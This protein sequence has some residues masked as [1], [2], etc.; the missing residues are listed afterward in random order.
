MG[1]PTNENIVTM[2]SDQRKRANEF[3]IKHLQG[4]MSDGKADL[5][6]L[7]RKLAV[8][9]WVIVILSVVMFL[10][11]VVLLSVPVFAA[12]D[13]RI[14]DL[15]SL[16]AAG[17]GIADLA[18][19]FLFRPI[20]RIHK[21]M[22]DMSQIVIALN[23]FQTQIGL[24]LMQMDATDRQSMGLAAEFINAAAKDSIVLVQQYFE[25][26]EQAS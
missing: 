7:R 23:S 15:Q 20:E 12:F 9:Y 5:K 17:F 8:T 18:A 2:D 13:G 14:K 26:V 21:I 6:N 24:R 10:L 16:I 19:L 1:E 11:G 4:S 22:G 25:T 3:I